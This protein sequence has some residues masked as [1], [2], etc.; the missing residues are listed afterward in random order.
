MDAS[1]AGC[2][3]ASGSKV[4]LSSVSPGG[5]TCGGLLRLHR[6]SRVVLASFNIRLVL[7]ARSCVVG[8][9]GEMVGY[10]VGRLLV[11][12]GVCGEETS[13]M[14]LGPPVV[15]P[16]HQL[17]LSLGPVQSSSLRCTLFRPAVSVGRGGV[18][19]G[20]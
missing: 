13:W 12:A 2:S 18:G 4:A 16:F 11:C 10:K 15:A 5:S 3:W 8:G 19:L 14:Y 9:W 7:W 20:S 1:I 17:L 6:R